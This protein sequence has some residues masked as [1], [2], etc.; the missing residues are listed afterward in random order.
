M[1]RFADFPDL[2]KDDTIFV[3]PMEPVV[4]RL[5]A[6][7]FR[8]MGCNAEVLVENE[9]TLETGL[10]HTAGGECTPCP[11]TL[12]SMIHT[13]E[14]KRLDP[15]RVIFF[16][17]TTC[18]PCRF[19]QYGTLAGLAF[20]RRGWDR[21]RVLGPN[22]ENSYGGLD[23][24][25]RRLLWHAIV[26]GDVVNKIVLKHRPYEINKGEVDS[27]TETWL[28]RLTADLERGGAGLEDT[29][30][31][32]VRAVGRIPLRREPKP[33]VGVVGEIYVRHDPFINK[34]LV[35]EIERLGG[36]VLACTVSEWILYCAAV[37]RRRPRRSNG[38][39]RRNRV[40]LFVEK[41][42]FE[43]VERK[44][45]KIA[46][47]LVHDR[48]EPPIE[49]VI[50]EGEKYVPW[51]FQ[52]ETIL[53]I[54]KTIL[55]IKRDRVDAVVSAAPAF[56]MPGTISAAIFPRIEKEYGVPVISIFYDGS[57]APNK[58]LAPYLHYLR[59]KRRR[60]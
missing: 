35:R 23:T 56:C 2:R 29:L 55:F 28:E 18:G 15:E 46:R 20:K 58:L 50:R 34:N 47:R 13:M 48:E 9:K 1:V 60:G 6:A 57:G 8:G 45:M 51:E 24:K 21:I 36:E 38:R 22:A 49:D 16:M 37:E 52:T 12:G 17:P 32:Y 19:G 43:A 25:T 54:G 30:R 42:W 4:A 5:A 11:T 39:K 44:Y 7:V 14:E 53:T 31:G 3:P 59:E 41:K 26:L 27:V 33:K 10:K 40:V